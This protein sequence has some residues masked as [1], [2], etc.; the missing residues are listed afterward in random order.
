MITDTDHFHRRYEEVFKQEQNKMTREEAIKIMDSEP[1]FSG[2]AW[3]ARFEALGLIKF[4]EP[5]VQ[6]VFIKSGPDNF[7]IPLFDI[8]S[9][10]AERGYKVVK[11]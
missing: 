11:I 9:A 8:A 2:A 5:K 7:T 10:L 4:E 1:S 3:I 6:S